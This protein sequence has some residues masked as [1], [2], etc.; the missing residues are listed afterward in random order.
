M[1]GHKIG[2][3]T[4]KIADY[5]DLTITI[6]SG[7]DA[8][9]GDSQFLSNKFGKRGWSAFQNDSKGA[10]FLQN[11]GIV[12]QLFGF[13][14]PFTLHLKPAQLMY[15]LRS[16]PNMP[17]D[18]D[19]TVNKASNFSSNDL[20]PLQFHRLCPPFLNKPRSIM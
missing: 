8:N 12:K 13:L 11:T 9:R 19:A 2:I 3:K 15:G 5:L 14:H 10:S 17:H 20:T 1:L 18:R 16:K 4:Q 7:A 6:R